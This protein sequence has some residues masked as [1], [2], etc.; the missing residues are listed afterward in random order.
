MQDPWATRASGQ[1]PPLQHHSYLDLHRISRSLLSSVHL[2]KDSS[3]YRCVRV[4]P[5]RR[6]CPVRLSRCPTVRLS[7]CPASHRRS[8]AYTS[9]HRIPRLTTS[10]S[11][12][13][14]KAE[15]YACVG[16]VPRLQRCLRH[17]RRKSLA[18]PLLTNSNRKNT[19]TTSPT[20]LKLLNQLRKSGEAHLAHRPTPMPACELSSWGATA[21]CSPTSCPRVCRHRGRWTTRSNSFLAQF[22][23]V[24]RSS[25]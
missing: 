18:T 17:R 10:S 24:V 25:E 8:G 21:T 13:D 12:L 2:D 11:I 23:R 9:T 7:G 16:V 19:S 1:A 14:K 5:V 20:V 15:A 4:N 22:P 3:A 6:R